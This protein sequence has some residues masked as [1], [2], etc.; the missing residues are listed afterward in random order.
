MNKK[1]NLRLFI[2][3]WNESDENNRVK[4]LKNCLNENFKYVDPHAPDELY[5][6]TAMNDFITV[7]KSRISHE[8]LLIAAPEIHHNAFRLKWKLE[9]GVHILSEGTFVGEFSD[10]SK[11]H[12]VLGFIDK[13]YGMN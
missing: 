5:G 6:I 9:K 1:E 11:I 8:L 12:S 10:E 4:T 7:F 3:S 2:S 13:F